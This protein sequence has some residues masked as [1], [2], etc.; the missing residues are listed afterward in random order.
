MYFKYDNYCFTF[1]SFL[2]KNNHFSFKDE[3]SI[4]W[5][6]NNLTLEHPK[7]SWMNVFD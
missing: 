1:V 3:I 7:I 6:L 2:M 5:N 4:H